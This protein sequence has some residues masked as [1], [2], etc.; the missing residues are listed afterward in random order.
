MH[1]TTAKN[2]AMRQ[3]ISTTGKA[4]QKTNANIDTIMI[5]IC[6]KY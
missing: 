5:K 2:K 6:K 1:K 4:K 3:I